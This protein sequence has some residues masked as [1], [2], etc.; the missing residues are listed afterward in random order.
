MADGAQRYHQARPYVAD[1]LQRV[2]ARGDRNILGGGF[3]RRSQ[4]GR[5]LDLP[6]LVVYVQRKLPASELP[7]ERL[8]PRT[9]DIGH[10]TVHVDVLE[11]GPLW[12][13]DVYTS[14]ERPAHGG[15]SIGHYQLGADGTLGC[16]VR[17]TT[18]G[19]LSI[20]SNNH[21][22]A[23]KNNCKVGD[24]ILQ[25][26]PGGDGGVWPNDTIATLTRWIP[27]NFGGYNVIDCAVAAV[28]YAPD[29][30]DAMDGGYMTPPSATEPA[31]GLLFG[32][33]SI[34]TYFCDIS[35]VCKQLQVEMLAGPSARILPLFDLH[36]DPNNVTMV[37]KTGRTT[38]FTSDLV[39]EIDVTA[40]FDY[41]D[42]QHITLS[43]IFSANVMAC[44]GDSGSLI[45]VTPTAKSSTP[46][47]CAGNFPSPS[48]AFLTAADNLTGIPFEQEWDTIR[49]ARDQYLLQTKIGRWLTDMLYVNQQTVLDRANSTILSD[50]D[51][52]LAQAL[53][54]KYL[55]EVKLAL[56]DPTRPDL[57]L[58][59]SNL[60]D[61]HTAVTAAENYMTDSEKNAA[62]NLLNI[63]NQQVGKK[64]SDLL[65][66]LDNDALLTLLKAVFGD[67]QGIADPY[68]P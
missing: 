62:S 58:T 8:L 6:S 43:H 24:A 18:N 59:Q 19:K 51:R 36:I 30:V 16:L 65:A 11:T 39:T 64:P 47:P 48:C 28:S 35:E 50:P 15:V 20:L 27:L 57:A 31:A 2:L 33:S 60:D 52:A 41:H 5:R 17:D 3:G 29:V 10:V 40:S 56:A 25:P 55:G 7:A 34:R 14:K 21:I 66:M 44:P 4:T 38:G 49:Q 46:V 13:G 9:M 22:L 61:I 54:A 32:G 67:L 42:G 68:D 23:N 45:S 12:A 63:V 1:A 53:Y 37:Q 26:G